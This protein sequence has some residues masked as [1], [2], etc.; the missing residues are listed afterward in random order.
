MNKFASIYFQSMQ[1][2]AANW[3]DVIKQLMREGM[4]YSEAAAESGRRG[5]MVRAKNLARTAAEKVTPQITPQA[6][7]ILFK[8][9]R[10]WMHA[11]APLS[12]DFWKIFPK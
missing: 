2:A 9:D 8:A 12:D 6:P 7:S 11:N 1:K 4:T 5:A 3:R 10:D